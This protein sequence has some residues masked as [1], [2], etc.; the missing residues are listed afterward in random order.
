[1]PRKIIQDGKEYTFNPGRNGNLSAPAPV[2]A[3]FNIR[4]E[5]AKT[6]PAVAG[7]EKANKRRKKK[8]GEDIK[9]ASV[10]G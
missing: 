9:V 4:R 8:P 10:R 3:E 5:P 1:M 7:L 2:S 6:V